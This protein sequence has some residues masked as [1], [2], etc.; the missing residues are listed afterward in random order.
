MSNYFITHLKQVISL[1]IFVL[2]L[3]YMEEQTWG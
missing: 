3:H 2:N 1:D